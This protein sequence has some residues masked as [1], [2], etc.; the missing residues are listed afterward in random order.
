M[1]L[2]SFAG[3]GDPTSTSSGRNRNGGP[4]NAGERPVDAAAKANLLGG[5]MDMLFEFDRYET[6]QALDLV[7]SRMNQWIRGQ[8]VNV[9]WQLDP[10]VAQ[11]P[12]RYRNLRWME[13]DVLGGLDFYYD[14]DGPFLREA[15]LLQEIGRHIRRQVEDESA[16][17]ADARGKEALRFVSRD[18]PEELRLAERLFDWTIKNVQL[19]EDKWPA[20]S[21]VYPLSQHWH[22]PYETVLLG[23]GTASDRAWV[24]LLLARQQRL[25]V[26]M[27]A[28]GESQNPE[29]LKPWIPA[30]VLARGEG[31]ARKTHLYLF[32]PALGIPIPGPGGKGIAT[33]TDVAADDSLLRRLDLDR[34][35]PYPI[36]AEDL[37]QVTA[38][39]EASP[40]YLSR[41]MKFVEANLSG[42]HRTAL[43]VQPTKIEA[44][45]TGVEHVRA[46]VELWTRPYETERVRL[47][48]S[49]EVKQIAQAELFP[50]QGLLRPLGESASSRRVTSRREESPEGGADADPRRRARQRV[51]L[52]VGR[53][54][55]VQGN[56][57]AEE[58]AVYYLIQAQTTDSEQEKIL[59]QILEMQTAGEEQRQQ[60]SDRAKATIREFRRSDQAAKLWLG[61]IKADIGQ[62][63]TAVKY[64]TTWDN[65]VWKPAADYNLAR[66]YEQQGQLAKAIE[67]YRLDESPQRHGNL[68]RS[69]RLQ[70]I[71]D[72][73]EKKSE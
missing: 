53:L 63:D 19:E 32:D 27:L 54:L 16:E 23:R 38:L 71:V 9:D 50:L 41:R 25:P 20:T 13:P 56:Y 49:D 21:E 44:Q 14:F 34:R 6:G 37:K 15:V 55:Q 36:K 69:R 59:E 62:L 60:L 67:I 12:A 73:G 58:G 61:Q 64:F 70:E 40:G 28:L 5:A 48:A 3:C 43:A 33:L 51:P 65:P 26:V 29:E 30:L 57:G 42:D 31:D 11:L 7:T 46:K 68:I 39:V 66:A 52:G 1:A 18:D 47:T 35:R 22:T 24:F 72:A 8:N 45:L 4:R 17:G 2:V 10:R